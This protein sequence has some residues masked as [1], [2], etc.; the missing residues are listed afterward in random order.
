MRKGW[1][2]GPHD[3]NPDTFG[4]GN[5]ATS[6]LGWAAHSMRSAPARHRSRSSSARCWSGGAAL[7]RA[8]G[9]WSVVTSP[10]ASGCG[11]HRCSLAAR[12]RTSTCRPC[13]YSFSGGVSA[14]R[15]G[16]AL[17][18]G[19]RAP[20]EP[21]PIVKCSPETSDAPCW[22]P[23]T[24][25]DNNGHRCIDHHRSHAACARPSST[26]LGCRFYGR[27]GQ[28]RMGTSSQLAALERM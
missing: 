14:E 5:K 13:C 22:R 7:A 1:T 16:R 23:D 17:G 8:T 10:A 28:P 3:L 12:S 15:D 19:K 11:R 9:G 2:P 20:A 18:S 25:E 27:T 6:T 21:F 4:K 26:A 24:T